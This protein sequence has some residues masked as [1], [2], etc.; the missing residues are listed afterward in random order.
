V[1]FIV[2][3]GVD[4]TYFFMQE[5]TFNFF[6]FFFTFLIFN[7]ILLVLISMRYSNSYRIL[8]R[9]SGYALATINMRLALEL[10]HPYNVILG[11]SA[12]IFVLGLVIAY[13]HIPLPYG[14]EE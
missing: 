14:E 11:V 13:N 1:V 2:M 8:F 9:N 4:L 12:A 10:N 7:D 6:H 5:H 3:I